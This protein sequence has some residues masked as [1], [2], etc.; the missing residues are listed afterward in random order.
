[1]AVKIIFLAHQKRGF[2]HINNMP[3]EDGWVFEQIYITKALEN[4]I[5]YVNIFKIIEIRKCEI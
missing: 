2:K 1:M 4:R 3:H 5:L